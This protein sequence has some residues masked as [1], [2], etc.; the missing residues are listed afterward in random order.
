LEP[1]PEKS[2]FAEISLANAKIKLLRQPTGAI[3]LEVKGLGGVSLIQ[4]G[5]ALDGARLEYW[6]M[7]GVN[8]NPTPEASMVQ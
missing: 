8:M 1:T 2:E 6:P 3:S 5:V 4:I 7:H